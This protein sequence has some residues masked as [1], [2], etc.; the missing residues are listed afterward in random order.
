MPYRDLTQDFIS[1]CSAQDTASTSLSPL[2]PIS[3]PKPSQNQS[4]FASLA[5]VIAGNLSKIG[6]QLEQMTELVRTQNS[7]G[8]S[9]LTLDVQKCSQSIKQNMATVSEQMKQLSDFSQ[10]TKPSQEEQ[11][12]QGV[13]SHLNKKFRETSSTYRDTLELQSRTLVA[14]QSR[15]DRFIGTQSVRP[16]PIA[17][18][19]EDTEPPTQNHQ[20][21]SQTQVSTSTDLMASR[22]EAVQSIES[23]L[24]ELAQLFSTF[25][26]VLAEQ[27]D[28]I[29]HIEQNVDEAYANVEG[30]HRHIERIWKRASNDR[31]LLLKIFGLIAIFVVVFGFVL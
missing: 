1:I 12:K 25:N 2:P 21:M 14:Q 26:N 10:S 4:R 9:N 6:V 18:S 23:H 15:R 5:A 24:A 11:H 8:D 27:Q 20:L 30:A 17:L 31:A 28:A 7:L 3:P 16:P 19:F 22:R 29:I 13:I